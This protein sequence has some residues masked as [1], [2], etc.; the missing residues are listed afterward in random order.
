MTDTETIAT[1]CQEHLNLG[2]IV[3]LGDEYGYPHLPLCFLD[4]VWLLGV[5][6]QGVQGV[7]KRYVK[8]AGL[9]PSSA[10]TTA[11]FLEKLSGYSAEE[12]AV[13]IFGNRQRTSTRGGILKAEAVVRFARILEDSGIQT[14]EDLVQQEDELPLVEAKIRQIPGQTSGL[15]WRYFLML[16][17]ASHLT[18]PDRQVLRFLKT[19]TGK[20]FSIE[21]AQALLVAVCEQ[22]RSQY[23]PISPRELDHLIWQY[24]RAR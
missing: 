24:Q 11:E 1:F 17:G 2:S 13:T 23:P 5:R 20:N 16:A 19:A 18:K 22:L 15:S 14:F 6:Y 8:W 9:D 3:W 10:H 7:V 4:A 21:N 12:A